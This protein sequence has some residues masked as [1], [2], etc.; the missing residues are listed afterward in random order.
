MLCFRGKSFQQYKWIIYNLVFQDRLSTR[1]NKYF[2]IEQEIYTTYFP[3]ECNSVNYFK[4]KLNQKV[5]LCLQGKVFQKIEWIIYNL[6]F[7]DRLSTRSN[8]FFSIEQ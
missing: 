1:S 6:E 5:M 7:Q 3:G 8:K 4:A 2:L